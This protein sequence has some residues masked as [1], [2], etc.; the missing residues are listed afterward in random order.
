MRV[1]AV[2][3]YASR[4]LRP[5]HVQGGQFTALMIVAA[6]LRVFKLLV[7]PKVA[8]RQ[9]A[10]AHSSVLSTCTLF[11]LL[12]VVLIP[13]SFLTLRRLMVI[14][15]AS[16]RLSARNRVRVGSLD[17]NRAR[18]LIAGYMSVRSGPVSISRDH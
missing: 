1:C 7:L 13:R 10:T 15:T 17:I 6:V 4:L 16:E 2:W 18:T 9:R 14:H 5:S 11:E 12:T 8:V 3:I